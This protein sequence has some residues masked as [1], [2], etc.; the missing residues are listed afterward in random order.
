MF[1]AADDR[2][3]PREH[4][5][6]RDE[7]QGGAFVANKEMD[8]HGMAHL[9][10]VAGEGP[11]RDD[12]GPDGRKQR[13]ER[14]DDNRR[15]GKEDELPTPEREPREEEPECG[16]RQAARQRRTHVTAPSGPGPGRGRLRGRRR[17]ARR[18]STGP[19]S[20]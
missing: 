10:P 7:V 9:G 15:E 13:A 14:E 5:N 16:R 3:R 8:L 11:D 18:G 1:L 19:A 4:V 6:E 12:P 17:F 20:G 2:E